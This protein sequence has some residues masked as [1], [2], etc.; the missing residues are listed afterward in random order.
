VRFRIKNKG[1][2]PLLDAAVEYLRARSTSSHD[3]ADL[4]S[5]DPS[6]QRRRAFAASRSRS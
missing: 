1:V 5:G 6:G 2:Q 3:G 4:K